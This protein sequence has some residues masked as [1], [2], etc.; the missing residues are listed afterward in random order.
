MIRARVLALALA[1]A[2]AGAVAATPTARAMSLPPNAATT[3]NAGHPWISVT[4]DP[5]GVAALINAAI[6][7]PASPER[8]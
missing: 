6:D 4:L 3:L 5:D 7:I 1:L 8:V 2:L